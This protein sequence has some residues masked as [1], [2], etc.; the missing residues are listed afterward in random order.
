LVKSGLLFPKWKWKRKSFCNIY[1]IIQRN[2]IW[3]N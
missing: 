3:K 1:T 2:K